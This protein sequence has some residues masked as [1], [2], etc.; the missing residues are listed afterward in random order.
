MDAEKEGSNVVFT[1]NIAA[2][3]Q[4]KEVAM[5]ELDLPDGSSDDNHTDKEQLSEYIVPPQVPISAFA[6]QPGQKVEEDG[7]P[8][9]IV[10]KP[11]F[12][13]YDNKPYKSSPA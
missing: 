4:H 6:S 8:S 11:Q 5:V 1:N 9:P 7:S 12:E 3:V 10:F 2:T 13:D